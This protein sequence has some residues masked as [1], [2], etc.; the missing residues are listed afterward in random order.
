[1]LPGALAR[2]VVLA[3]EQD[4]ADNPA[5]MVWAV[6]VEAVPGAPCVYS[7]FLGFF[8]SFPWAGG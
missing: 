5:R 8:C 6:G 2:G 1:M 3:G 7:L 4:P